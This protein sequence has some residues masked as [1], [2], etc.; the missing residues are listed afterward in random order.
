MG[1]AEDGEGERGGGGGRCDGGASLAEGGGECV[2]GGL[3]SE[4]GLSVADSAMDSVVD[5][6]AHEDG[7]EAE[8]GCGEAADE[9]TQ[10]SGGP[11][12]RD[13]EAGEGGEGDAGSAEGE[14]QKESAAKCRARDGG[15]EVAADDGLV[16]DSVERTADREE[17][18]LLGCWPVLLDL[19]PGSV[20]F[21][22]ESSATG[23]IHFRRGRRQQDHRDCGFGA[24]FGLSCFCQ[25]ASAHQVDWQVES[26]GGEE[27][28]IE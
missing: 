26:G 4:E 23:G 10:R 6:E 22:D 2:G 11:D 18:H 24:G 19:V 21:G 1:E 15:F 27:R 20:Q 7:G 25:E 8:S 17:F 28:Q 3:S 5:A 16:L 9:E 12:Q 14:E 13:C